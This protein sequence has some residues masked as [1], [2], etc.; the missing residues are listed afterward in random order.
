MLEKA[1]IFLLKHEGNLNVDEHPRNGIQI[2]YRVQPRCVGL[3]QAI[4][5]K[6]ENVIGVN[7]IAS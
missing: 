7:P 6:I 4:K 1:F 5:S 2:R 3:H